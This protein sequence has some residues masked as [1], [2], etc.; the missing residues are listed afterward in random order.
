MSHS[1][2]DS[3]TPRCPDHDVAMLLRG[4]MGTPAR[5]DSTLQSD[6]TLVYFCNV[7]GCGQSKLVSRKHAQIPAPGFSQP[8][9]DYIRPREK[10]R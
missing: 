4:K 7:H 10:G 9:P 6:Y 1:R 8:R 5:F 3:L 2:D